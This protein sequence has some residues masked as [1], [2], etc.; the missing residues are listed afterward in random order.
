M[1]FF[2]VMFPIGRTNRGFGLTA[3][4]RKQAID[5]MK[6]FDIDSA[7]VYH[8][9]SRDSDPI[10]GNAALERII[11]NDDNFYKIWAYDLA[12]VDENKGPDDFIREALRS[13]VKAIMINPLMR[14]IRIIRSNRMNI[15]AELMEQRRMPLILF[16]R[17]WDV[18]EDI[19]DW[20]ELA[21]FCNRFPNLPV[22]VREWRSRSN[23]PMF[24]ALQATEN[25][26][27][28]LAS[29]WQAQMIELLVNNFG[30]NRLVF[31][32]GL[33]ELD[34]G[35]FQAV[36]RYANISEADKKKVAYM[37]IRDI[38]GAANYEYE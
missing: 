26:I 2:D 3:I 14:N 25:L 9:V 38:L 30:A 5:L 27:I 16:Y 29:V 17:Q 18:A 22:I 10:L 15:L 34:A 1:N 19:I 21:E 37:N 35:M 32:L 33:P 28:S 13:H 4:N 20:Y 31:S 23:R 6:R 7:F 8:T 11:T 12:D 24:D 36:V